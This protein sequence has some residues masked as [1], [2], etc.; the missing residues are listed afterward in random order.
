MFFWAP[1]RYRWL[2]VLVASLYF[3][4]TWESLAAVLGVFLLAA[5]AYL[6]ALAMHRYVRHRKLFCAAGLVVS[7]GT[8]AA[9]KYF[10]FF[11]AQVAGLLTSLNMLPEGTEVPAL[12]WYLP[13]GYSFVTFTIASYIID[14][15]RGKIEP[16]KLTSLAAF[17]AFFPKILAGPIERATNFL[18]QWQAGRSFD[19]LQASHGM[20][21][22]LWG[23]FK[24]VVI[25][26]R[27]APFVDQ[28]YAA[29]AFATPVELIVGTYFYAFQIYCDFS[30]Y[31]DIAIG[32]F[33]ILGFNLAP[34]F[35]HSYLSRSVQEFWSGRWHITL[36]TWFRDYLYI[37]LGGSRVALWRVALN[38]MVVFVISGI[39]HAGMVG[40]EVSWT[41]A[42]WGAINGLFVVFAFVTA[43]LWGRLGR[44]MPKVTA[45]PA[46]TLVKIVGTFHLITFTWIFFRAD[47]MNDAFAVMTSIY[48][49]IER[50]PMLVSFYNYG[51]FD[52]ILS[53]IL[54]AVLLLVEAWTDRRS[55][56][57]RLLSW[58]APLRWTY[59][60]ILIGALIVIGQWGVTEFIYMQF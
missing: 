45:S 9:L 44:F 19:F 37:P 56:W 57:D 6:S 39:W 59:Y 60:Y 32:A 10:D 34:N 1:H 49:N 50:L 17:I 5:A 7:L 23:L 47:T 21:L 20:H 27:L 14:A 36:G 2:V 16:A 35:R 11:L 38:L 55:M 43:P 26:D 13:I 30:G 31:T 28:A 25:A 29:P 22:I 4:A 40:T 54:I 24:K 48:E 51:D 42:V 58:P 46:L 18:P 12:E 3:Y 53:V 8:L 41:F 33:M 15:Y 52:F